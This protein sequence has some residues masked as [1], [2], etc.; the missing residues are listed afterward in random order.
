MTCSHRGGST[1]ENL[2][3]I[4]DCHVS[5]FRQRSSR[6][7]NGS[8]RERW[9]RAIAV[10]VKP[11]GSYGPRAVCT[12]ERARVAVVTPSAIAWAPVEEVSQTAPS[13]HL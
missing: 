3:T 13:F 9:C 10:A 2:E 5:L 6:D 12:K 1:S 7:G 8:E 4:K 11:G